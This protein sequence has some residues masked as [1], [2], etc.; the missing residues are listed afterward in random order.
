M[1]GVEDVFISHVDMRGSEE[2]WSQVGVVGLCDGED[3]VCG[4]R[5]SRK[6]GR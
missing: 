6:V 1:G 2:V 5:G 4:M 3:V